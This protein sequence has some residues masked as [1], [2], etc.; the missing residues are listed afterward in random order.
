MAVCSISSTMT[1]PDS[2]G[3]R[4]GAEVVTFLH[5]LVCHAVCVTSL[6]FCFSFGHNI[7]FEDNTSRM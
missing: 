5:V 2:S 4:G 6:A 1:Y 3:S 7:A